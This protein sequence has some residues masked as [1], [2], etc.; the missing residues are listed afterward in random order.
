MDLERGTALPEVDGSCVRR[1]SPR[2]ETPPPT[3]LRH[4][5]Q[6]PRGSV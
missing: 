3:T 4:G 2:D 5:R 1:A 6:P